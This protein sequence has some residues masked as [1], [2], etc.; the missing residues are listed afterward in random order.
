M[1]NKL[2]KVLSLILALAMILTVAGCAGKPAEENEPVEDKPSDTQTSTPVEEG[3]E[4]GDEEPEATVTEWGRT[5]PDDTT[6]HYAFE[7]YAN[8]DWWS[9]QPWGEDAATAHWNELFNI[10]V[11]WTKPDA[12]AAAKLNLMVTSG[13]LPEVIYMDRNSDFEKLCKMGIFVDLNTLKYEGN[14]Y[15]EALT[16]ATQ[17]LLLVDGGLYSF[18]CWPRKGATG[19]ND[20]WQVLGSVYE[21]LGKPEIKTMEDMHDYVVAVKEAGAKNTKGETLI[22]F[23]T[24]ETSNGSKIINAFLR[25]QGRPN[26]PQDW[27]SQQQG[28]SEADY[29]FAL[30]DEYI[31]KAIKE[32]NKWYNEGLFPQTVFTDSVD[33]TKEKMSTAKAA[34]LY[35]DFSQDSVYKYNQLVEQDMNDRYLV[36][37]W[38]VKES[39]IF[40]THE[41]AEYPAFGD[42]NGTTGGGGPCITTSAENPGRIFDLFGYMWSKQ[43]SIEI[44]YG[45]EGLLWEG[46]DENGNPMLKKPEAAFTPEEKNAAGC[47]LWAT[48]AHSDNIDSTKF[49]V[50]EMAPED[51]RDWTISIQANLMSPNE[52]DDDPISLPGQK[53]I[54]DDNTNVYNVIDAASDLGVSRQL[55]H[56]ECNAKVPMMLMAKDEAEIDAL[57]ADLI[58][59]ANS[60]GKDDILAAYN[61]KHEA[62]IA[63]AGYSY[64]DLFYAAQG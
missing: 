23:I 55:I 60:N 32:A 29:C 56:D 45:P 20:T 38:D 42:E 40:V 50:N 17:N 18:P 62:N 22:P 12:D 21:Q 19:G 63:T 61:E 7:I 16:Q 49:A 44:M 53:Y 54:C 43:G 25:A 51:Q 37:G 8:Y 64:Y 15:D 28:G 14:P 27:W 30:E 5:G 4:E 57:I 33:Q 52:S 36:L 34:V 41:Y 13:E 1:K 48:P 3:T 6:E 11:E 58:A 47:W 10:E 35:Y 46:L 31:V 24:G 2:F 9:I 39:P 26:R 59:F